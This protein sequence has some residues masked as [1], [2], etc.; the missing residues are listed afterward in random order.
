[1]SSTKNDLFGYSSS[2]EGSDGGGDTDDLIAA[3]KSQPIATKKKSS[4]SG[5]GGGN[6]SS[7]KKKGFDMCRGNQPTNALLF[8][9]TTT[10]AFTA[11]F[12]AKSNTRIDF[13]IVGMEPVD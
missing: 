6:S 10:T 1:M 3:A 7:K 12:V 9:G 13:T 4:G 11:T 8:N 2:S 5:G